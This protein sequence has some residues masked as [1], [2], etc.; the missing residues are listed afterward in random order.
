MSVYPTNR[1]K[2]GEGARGAPNNQDLEE[3]GARGAPKKRGGSTKEDDGVLGMVLDRD[4]IIRKRTNM[5]FS[6]TRRY[7]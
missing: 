4:K 1:I 6:Y 5:L 7:C 3:E 2:W